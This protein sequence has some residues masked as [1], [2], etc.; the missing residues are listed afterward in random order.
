MQNNTALAYS[1]PLVPDCYG[2][3]LYNL[4]TRRVRLCKTMFGDNVK[5]S[6]RQDQSD[7][8]AHLVKPYLLVVPTTS[9]GLTSTAQA[10]MESFVLARTVTFIAQFDGRASEAEWQAVNDIE[11]GEKQLLG[12]FLGWKPVAHYLPTIYS[13]MRIMGTKLPDVMVAY[14]FVFS[15]EIPAPEETIGFDR[16]EIACFEEMAISA[17]A[18]D[19][20]CCVT[21]EVHE[22]EELF[23]Q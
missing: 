6:F 18:V 20:D 19:L 14:G 12:C 22:C 2:E 5:L 8:W 16:P 15:E 4:V 10:E 23:P 7:H 21:T 13:G 17:R 1:N 9:R 11:A 3:S